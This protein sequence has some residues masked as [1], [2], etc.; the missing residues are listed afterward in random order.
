MLTIQ[1]KEL[2]HDQLSNQENL[3]EIQIIKLVDIHLRRLE[4]GEGPNF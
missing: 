3:W 4:V 2:M 1:Q